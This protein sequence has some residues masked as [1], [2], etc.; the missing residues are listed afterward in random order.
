MLSGAALSIALVIL[1]CTGFSHAQ[2][3]ASY[4]RWGFDASGVDRRVNPGDSFFDFA[5][6]AWDART[7]I[8]ADKARYGTFDA[9]T[10][11]TQ[12]RLRAIVEEAAKSGASPDTDVGKIGALYN[13]FM[14]EQ[15]IEQL[16]LAPIAGD[17]AEILNAR[18]K[19]DI[20][21]L[22][23][24]SKNGFGAGLFNIAVDEDE[25]DPTRNTLHASQGG[26]GLPDRDYYLRDAFRDKKTKYRDYVAR[27]L[28]MVG[29]AQPQQRADDVV[30]FETRVAEA[31]W[32]RAESRDRDKTY[33]PLTLAELDALAPGFAWSA[34]LAAADAGGA[35]SIIV[36]QKTAFPK[37]AKIFDETSLETLQAWQAFRV[38]DQA[39]PYL[40]ARFVTA[41]FE[42][43]GKALV[44]QAQEQPRWRRATQL[45]GSSLGEVVGREYVARHFPADSKAKMEELVDQ[46]KRALR[47][48]IENLSWMTPET[49]ARALEKL[50]LFGVKIGY[51]DKWRDYTTLKIDPADLVGNVRRATAFRWAYAVAKLDKPVDRAEWSTTPQVVNAYYQPTRN[52]IVFPA[53]ILQP[54]FFDPNADMAINYGG[55]GGVIGHEMTHAFDDQGRKSDGHGVLTD[56]WQPADAAKF[57]AEAAKYGAQYDAYAVAPGVNVKGAQTMGENIA[58][59]GGVLLALDAYRA[60][61]NGAP[62]PV[63]DGY[64]GDQ[65]VFLGWAQ[66][67][68]TKSRP[69]ALKQQ[70]T[71]D[72]HSPARFRVDGPLRNV[73]AWYDAFGVKPG[74]KLYLKPE[75]RVRIW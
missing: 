33:N 67:W 12:A 19:T 49:K 56:W 37:L 66:V 30:A 61:L 5:N 4:G 44:G 69:D 63:L 39:A 29:W 54:P 15:R 51:P 1:C 71:S 75:D 10:D 42:F 48:R 74:D 43:R 68:R 34:W 38:V 25:K 18:S 53:G 41:R 3:S 45:I 59:L 13:A 73:D 23:G 35:H 7:V 17:L 52:E 6:G 11:K 24:R 36:R 16:D 2:E 58:D 46:L 9:L 14:D 28:G 62:A 21:V 20:A 40:S 22:M 31:S 55:I 72:S 65:R 32:S 27:L 8:P 60:S 50:A 57:K 64:T 47:S 26:L 70:I